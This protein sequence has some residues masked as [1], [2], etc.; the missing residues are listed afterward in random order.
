MMP[1]SQRKQFI[2][3]SFRLIRR[4]GNKSNLSIRRALVVLVVHTVLKNMMQERGKVLFSLFSLCSD[5]KVWI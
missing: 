2:Q 3:P 4:P 1:R 5:A